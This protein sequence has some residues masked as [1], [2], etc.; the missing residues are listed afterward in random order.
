M[1]KLKWNLEDFEF[2]YTGNSQNSFSSFNDENYFEKFN[3]LL[4]ND[5]IL[6]ENLEIVKKKMKKAEDERITFDYFIEKE[7]K[8]IGNE[9]D[10]I[11]DFFNYFKWY[12]DNSGKCF[13][14]KIVKEANT[15]NSEDTLIY[16]KDDLTGK[17][18]YV[19]LPDGT[20]VP[21]DPSIF[22]DPYINN[23]G[24][25][26]ATIISESSLYQNVPFDFCQG[27]NTFLEEEYE[28]C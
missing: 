22:P 20:K 2:Y 17:I 14:N 11:K 9:L 18:I 3:H 7:F 23:N 5:F 16:I 12:L 25:N 10:K 19:L 27:E 26:P 1:K 6:D 24:T 21:Y 15:F 4:E 28:F 8:I 13:I